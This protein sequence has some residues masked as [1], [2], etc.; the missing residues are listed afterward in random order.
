MN[1]VMHTARQAQC[2]APRKPSTNTNSVTVFGDR[3][4]AEFR[5]S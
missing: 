4:R 3:P 1:K 2:L 5:S